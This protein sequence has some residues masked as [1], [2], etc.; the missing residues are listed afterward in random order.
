MEELERIAKVEERCKSNTHRLDKLESI[1]DEIH[2]LSKTMVE[3]V[4]EV[5][6]TNE[7]VNN[8]DAK[9]DRMDAR[10]DEIEK[11]PSREYGNIKKAVL[12]KAIG[13]VIGLLTT[14]IIWAMIQVF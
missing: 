5:K 13:V 8:L 9:V 10:V 3:L 12:D 11:A 6:H 1:V 4:Q 7:T 2:T 14:G